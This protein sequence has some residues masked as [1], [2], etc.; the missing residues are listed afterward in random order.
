MLRI[1][2]SPAATEEAERAVIGRSDRLG[3]DVP[4]PPGPRR[5]G[6]DQLTIALPALLAA[7]L[8]AI[9]LATRSLWLDEGA[10][11][12]IASQHGSALWHGIAHDGGNMLAYYLLTHQVIAWFGDGAIAIRL[13]SLIA[14]AL[15]AAIVAALALRLFADRRIALT[16]GALTAVSLPLIFWGQDARGYSLMAALGAGSFTALVAILRTPPGQR[17]CAGAVAAYG[18]TTLT[19]VYVGFDSLLLAA[20]QLLLVLAV[21]RDRARV[22]VGC[23]AAVAVLSMPLLVLALNRGSRQ[24]F[25]VPKLGTTTLGQAAVTLTSAGFSP[26]FNRTPTT[27]VAVALTGVLLAAAL[28]A[29]V[30]VIRE[31]SGRHAVALIVPTSWL[32][33]P[34]ILALAAGLVGEPIELSRAAIL[35]IPALALLL[36][37]GF[38][39][40]SLPR[41]AGLATLGALLALRALQIVPTYGVSPEDWHAAT[42]YVLA[43][44]RAD[45]ACVAFYP[46]DGRTPFDYYLGGSAEGAGLIP[47]LPTTPWSQVRPYVEKYASLRDPNQV[48]ARCPRLWLIT[49][50]EGQPYGPATS[51]RHYLRYLGLLSQL[52]NIYGGPTLQRFGYSAQVHVYRFVRR[53]S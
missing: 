41:G 40:P 49:S 33:V 39:H 20:A 15:T 29:A 37:W 3:R 47:V 24:L 27:I 2:T 7:A 6:A 45:P 1:I 30:R 17:P 52:S 10:T 23:L 11:V 5:L 44:T 22:I 14:D 31:R 34:A 53:T 48:A 36:G 4:L 19:A 12:A 9:E 46:E 51:L 21:F 42:S 50:H 25:W 8:C 16:A 35:L 43:A 38:W 18:L 13:P 26:N 32:L 28:V